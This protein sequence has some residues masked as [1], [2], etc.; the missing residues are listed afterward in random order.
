MIVGRVIEIWRHPVKSMAGG[1]LDRC[2]GGE[3]GV[4]GDRCGAVRV[5]AGTVRVGDPVGLV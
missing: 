2:R 5:S 4:P 1:E 3:R